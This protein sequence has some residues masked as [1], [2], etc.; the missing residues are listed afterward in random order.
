MVTAFTDRKDTIMRKL[1]FSRGTIGIGFLVA[2]L[3]AWPHS[4]TPLQATTASL[5]IDPFEMTATY[6]AP[7]LVEQ[8]DAI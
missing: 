4:V 3:F 5:S 8:W 7:L 6:K 2:A 1:L